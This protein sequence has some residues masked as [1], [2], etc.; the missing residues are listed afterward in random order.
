MTIRPSEYARLVQQRQARLYRMAFCYVKNQQDA[1]DIVS[2]AVCRGL[3]H[4]GQ[5][6]D[7]DRFDPWLNRIV[8]H[9]A[10]DHL[11]RPDL[12][13]PEGEELLPLL[14]AQEQTLEPEDS[15]DL[16]AALEL[17]APE[18]RTD[19]ILRFFEEYTFREM[20][21]ILDQPESTIKSRLYRTLAKLRRRL[22]PDD[23]TKR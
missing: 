17:L 18:E 2:E 3:T 13:L 23:E 22:Q 8:I 1:L 19:I 11:R 10:L 14:P 15:M 9:A 12:I 7:R 21:Q 4:L 5:L 6:K 20:A 16:Y